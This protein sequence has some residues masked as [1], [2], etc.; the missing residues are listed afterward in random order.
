M[1]QNPSEMPPSN[2]QSGKNVA[3]GPATPAK[4]AAA[5]NGAPQ[6]AAPN[7][8][9]ETTPNADPLAMLRADHRKVEQLFGAFEKAKT[10]DEKSDLA[11]QICNELMVHTLLEEEIVYPAC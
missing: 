4:N 11:E 1:P 2:G 8:A 10:N 9:A 3:A 6:K 7:N 5:K